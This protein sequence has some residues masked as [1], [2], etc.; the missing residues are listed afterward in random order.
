MKNKL[1]IGSLALN[2]ILA[3]LCLYLS[4]GKVIDKSS[5]TESGS[6]PAFLSQTSV[7]DDD[8]IFMGEDRLANC[9][10]SVF[11][12]DETCK[13]LA[14]KGNNLDDDSKRLALLFPNV[15]PSEIFMM[16]GEQELLQGK[17]VGDF[18]EEYGAFVSR[19][20]E[21][22]PSTEVIIMSVLP[23]WKEHDNQFNVDMAENV[24]KL[25]ILLK[26]LANQKG[27][28]FLNLYPDFVDVNG[29]MNSRFCSS[30][31]MALRHSAYI[32]MKDRIKD[33]IKN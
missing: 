7:N 31:G 9:D 20:Q 13:T 25:N 22:F 33:Y 16:Y 30:D 18:A 3:V 32:I 1:F 6:A 23:M 26:L 29:Y 19:I 2:V 17:N 12:A 27:Y 4:L 14:F 21:R 24:K 8:V 15:T 28:S 10:W 11:L 5:N